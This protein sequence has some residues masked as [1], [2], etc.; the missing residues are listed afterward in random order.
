MAPGDAGQ[1]FC[2]A[3]GFTTQAQPHPSAP[4]DGPEG[5]DSMSVVPFP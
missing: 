3:R 4:A 2:F 5:L 1:G